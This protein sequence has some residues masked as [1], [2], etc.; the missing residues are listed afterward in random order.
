MNIKTYF[1]KNNVVSDLDRN[2]K[3]HLMTACYYDSDWW[4][5]KLALEWWN[6]DGHFNE[7]LYRDFLLEKINLIEKSE[8]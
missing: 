6:R 1:R 8:N 7:E 2:K 5:K 4:Q 3:C